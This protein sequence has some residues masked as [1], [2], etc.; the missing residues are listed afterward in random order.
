MGRE[1]GDMDTGVRVEEWS[2]ERSQPGAVPAGL[3]CFPTFPAL[4]CRALACRRSAA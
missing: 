3:A 4:P 2:A 1:G